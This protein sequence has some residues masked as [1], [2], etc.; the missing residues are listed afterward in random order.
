MLRAQQM[1]GAMSYSASLEGWCAE[2]VPYNCVPACVFVC[3]VYVDN[4]M[5]HK[6]MT[7]LVSCLLEPDIHVLGL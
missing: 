4:I 1:S 6:R 7:V 2:P 5:R 3:V